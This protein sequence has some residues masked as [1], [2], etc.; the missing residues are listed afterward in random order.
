MLKELLWWNGTSMLVPG[1]A[2][3]R[4]GGRLTSLE[5]VCKSET[6]LIWFFLSLELTFDLWGQGWAWPG[7]E[8]SA[9]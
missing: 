8:G 1:K 7:K 9:K 3:S 4:C 2:D 6:T 5:L